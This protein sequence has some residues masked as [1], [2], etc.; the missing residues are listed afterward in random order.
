MNKTAYSTRGNFHIYTSDGSGRDSY[1]SYNNAGL[2]NICVSGL[3]QKV[4]KKRPPF[5]SFRSLAHK[6]IVY[7]YHPDGSGR[8]FYIKKN[9]DDY[10][11]GYY[12]LINRKLSE[13]LRKNEDSYSFSRKKLVLSKSEI[14]HIKELNKIQNNVVNRLYYKC[15]D[16]FKKKRFNST[17]RESSHIQKNIKKFN[18]GEI[19]R[20]KYE[21]KKNP[22]KYNSMISYKNI[23]VCP[24]NMDYN[25]NNIDVYNNSNIINDINSTHQKGIQ[26][27]KLSRGKNN[28]AIDI[29]NFGIN[30][31]NKNQNREI[32]SYCENE[33]PKKDKS[34]D[35]IK[36]RLIRSK[37]L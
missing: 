30:Q 5:S 18:D 9:E 15:K 3:T 10:I 23:R 13:I 2:W 21:K 20:I 25:C 19:S 1:I 22:N 17:F 24:E 6:P 37:A 8:D 4:F 16:K 12:P 32:F 31:K 33:L 14:M 28:S 7:K 27:K 29:R 34:K 26:I 36:Y 35:I 11:G